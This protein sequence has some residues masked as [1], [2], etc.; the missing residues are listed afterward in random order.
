MNKTVVAIGAH[1]DDIEIGCAGTLLNLRDKGYRI[2]LIVLTDGGNWKDKDK[3]IRKI[4]QDRSGKM[5]G[6]DSIYYLNEKDGK[7]QVTSNIIDELSNILYKENPDIIFTHYGDDTHQDHRNANMITLSANKNKNIIMYQSV[8]SINFIANIFFDITE[9][10]DDKVKVLNCFESQ[11]RKY[12]LRGDSL[13]DSIEIFGKIN[14]KKIG[15]KFAEGFIA[16]N[17]NTECLIG[18]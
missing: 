11:V 6:A 16:Y 1:H 15:K 14:G 4:E 10:F 7:L 3:D 8:S 5:L 17:L 18:E 9:C 12:N 2:I 13:I